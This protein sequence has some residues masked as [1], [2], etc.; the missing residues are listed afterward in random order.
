[1]KL[2]HSITFVCAFKQRVKKTLIAAGLKLINHT[3]THDR[4]RI[5][6][7]NMQSLT[8]NQTSEGLYERKGGLS[9]YRVT[10]VRSN[11]GLYETNVIN[12][13]ECRATTQTSCASHLVVFQNSGVGARE[14]HS[15]P[16]GAILL[17]LL[18]LLTSMHLPQFNVT[19]LGTVTMSTWPG[20]PSKVERM[21]VHRTY[22]S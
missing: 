6:I 13:N 20:V 15:R 16:S 2:G 4:R 21:K 22:S 1:M 3:E 14:L 10:L 11:C 18:S 19:G 12:Q 17:Y 5:M 7:N 8:R 9:M